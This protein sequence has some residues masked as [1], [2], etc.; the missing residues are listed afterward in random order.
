MSKPKISYNEKRK[1]VTIIGYGFENGDQWPLP[2]FKSELNTFHGK[3]YKTLKQAK[4]A[5][6]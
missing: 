4:G 1:P 5:M 3:V 6:K 2:I